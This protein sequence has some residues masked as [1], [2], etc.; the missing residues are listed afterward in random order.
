LGI[1][2]SM[3]ASTDYTQPDQ[4][5]SHASDGPKHPTLTSRI[6]PPLTSGHVPFQLDPE[7]PLGPSWSIVVLRSLLLP[8]NASPTSPTPHRS[9]LTPVSRIGDRVS[10]IDGIS[11]S[12]RKH[13]R[14]AQIDRKGKE[15]ERYVKRA[16]EWITLEN[17]TRAA[18]QRALDTKESLERKYKQKERDMEVY[19]QRLRDTGVASGTAR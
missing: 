3:S 4:P 7:I 9:P 1:T 18:E 15:P 12:G 8:S 17:R 2:P 10:I 14:L 6:S 11:Y 5:S 19:A 13:F 16:P